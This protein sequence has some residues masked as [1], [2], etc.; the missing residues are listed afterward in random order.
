MRI[1]FFSATRKSNPKDTC[2]LKSINEINSNIKIAFD[3]NNNEG[4]PAAY[5]KAMD[6]ALEENWD[7]LVLAHDDIWLEYD[8]IP[9]LIKLFETYDLIGVAGTSQ[10]NLQSPALWHIMGGGFGSGKLHG[11]VAH[12]TDKYKNMTN[13]GTYPHRAVML[14]GVFMAMNRKVIES[15]RFDTTNPAKAHF[16]DLDFSLNCHMMGHRV[17]VGDVYIT[18]ESPGLK[19]FT[20]E[21]KEAESWF[22]NKYES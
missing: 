3:L 13:F 22:L 7:A 18:H 19:E 8:P 15:A 6:K 16:Y 1:A 10:I 11:A 21:W 20:D 9:K 12:G 5:N 4:L 17:G 2:L 14:D